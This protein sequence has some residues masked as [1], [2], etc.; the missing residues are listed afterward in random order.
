MKRLGMGLAGAWAAAVLAV[1]CGG[2]APYGGGVG[3]RAQAAAGGTYDGGG[4]DG[5]AKDGGGGY[6]QDGGGDDGGGGYAQDG[7]GYD[8]GAMDGGYGDP[9]EDDKC[10][11][12]PGPPGP[13]GASAGLDSTTQ[14]NT[15]F[16]AA[17][18]G[19]GGAFLLEEGEAAWQDLAD[20]DGFPGDVIDISVTVGATGNTIHVVLLTSGGSVYQAE[21]TVNPG[22][23]DVGDD[24]DPFVL[25]PA[26]PALP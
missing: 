11:C 13:P 26:F 2:E 25:Q 5:G 6:A 17:A 24:C 20:V 10:V 21:C 16:V 18:P 22:P 9:C 12:P 1:G 14:G 3:S 7:G 8:G 4:T 19:D 23:V 15:K